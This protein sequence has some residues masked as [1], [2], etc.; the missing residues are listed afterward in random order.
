MSCGLGAPVDST[1][2]GVGCARG[3]TIRA[4]L[5]NLLP[6]ILKPGLVSKSN[7]MHGAFYSLKNEHR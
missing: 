1:G 7:W 2:G 3:D 6:M 4:T 5:F